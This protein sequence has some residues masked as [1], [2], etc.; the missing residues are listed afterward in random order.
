V[1]TIAFQRGTAVGAPYLVLLHSA[2]QPSAQEWSAYVQGV[3]AALPSAKGTLHI[4][5][6][7]DGGAPN[8]AQRKQLAEAFDRSASPGLT[9]V[10]STSAFVRGVVTAFSWMT[11]SHALAHAP[12]E[13][14][15]VCVECHLDAASVL[16]DMVKLQS[17][18]VAVQVLG[19]IQHL[20]TRRASLPRRG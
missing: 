20:Y 10:F 12:R 8:A 13:F 5:V 14:G 3:E 4:F 6:A 11:R 2:E 1:Q 7:T 15:S 16:G 19:Q 18:F 9:H 17:T